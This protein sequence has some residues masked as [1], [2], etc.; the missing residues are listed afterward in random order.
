MQLHPSNNP[1][2]H[3]DKDVVAMISSEGL[4]I[5]VPLPFQTF[6]DVLGQMNIITLEATNAQ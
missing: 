2:Y 1:V 4:A 6:G 3:I 5:A